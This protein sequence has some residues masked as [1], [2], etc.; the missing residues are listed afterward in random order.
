MAVS[1]RSPFIESW[2]EKGRAKGRAEGLVEA[3]A[4]DLPKALEVRGIQ[5]TKAQRAKVEAS[6]D[7]GQLDTWFSNALTATSADEVF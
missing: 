4:E 2:E 5:V 7:L 6:T 1:Y 3:R